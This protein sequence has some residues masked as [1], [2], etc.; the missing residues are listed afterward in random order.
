M[1]IKQEQFGSV[2]R[3]QSFAY[4]TRFPGRITTEGAN[5]SLKH[6]KIAGRCYALVTKHEQI[7][8][9]GSQPIYSKQGKNAN[10]IWWEAPQKIASDNYAGSVEKLCTRP[11]HEGS[12][13]LKI[14]Q[15]RNGA[16]PQLSLL[17]LQGHRVSFHNEL[18]ALNKFCGVKTFFTHPYLLRVKGK[19]PAS[20]RG[21]AHFHFSHSSASLGEQNNEAFSLVPR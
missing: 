1:S 3:L 4:Q 17:A 14:M 5:A 21:I 10:H 11:T 16:G 18:V 9:H 19:A 13:L 6:D 12:R 2:T 8:R 15:A 20:C 7:S